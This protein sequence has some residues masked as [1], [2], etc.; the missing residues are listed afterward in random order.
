MIRTALLLFLVG[1]STQVFSHGGGHYHQAD[2]LNTW[3]LKSN[4]VIEGN[5]SFGDSISIVLEQRE[6]KFIK[7]QISDLSLQDQ[8]LAIFKI[9]K[10]ELVKK[11]LHPSTNG[12]LQDLREN[13]YNTQRAQ[14]FNLSISSIFILISISI[15]FIGVRLIHKTKSF[16]RKVFI[17]NVGFILLVMALIACKK[18]TDTVISFSKTRTS[19]IDSAFTAFKPAVATRWDNDYFYVSS[20]GFP[21]QNVMVGITN[22][23]QQV[24]IPQFYTGNNSWSI[25]LQPVYASNPLSTQTNLMKG[26]IAIAVDD[27]P[28]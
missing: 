13:A 5:F 23:Q 21:T 17:V 24:P 7:I 25:P 18:S 28:I 4:K 2:V 22:W 9:K 6:G 26:A 10:L 8:K 3:L 27:I 11:S 12:T 19:F 15:V 1:T 20:N 14:I 16:N